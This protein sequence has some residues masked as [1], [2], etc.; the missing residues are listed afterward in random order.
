MGVKVEDDLNTEKSR[1]LWLEWKRRIDPGH[2]LDPK[3]RADESYRAGLTMVAD[4][5]IPEN[6]LCRT[7]AK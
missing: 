2:Y 4:G 7:K 1:K 3:T 5:L 6:S